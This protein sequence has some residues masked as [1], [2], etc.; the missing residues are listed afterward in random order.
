M[1]KQ[2]QLVLLSIS[3]SILWKT[4][5]LDSFE[6]L[7]RNAKAPQQQPNMKAAEKR[8]FQL[9]LSHHQLQD[10]DPTPSW[11]LWRPF[12]SQINNFYLIGTPFMQSLDICFLNYPVLIGVGDEAID[13]VIAG[14]IIVL[15]HPRWIMFKWIFI[16]TAIFQTRVVI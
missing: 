2:W 3:A 10:E 5:L 1:C 9:N 7:T 15:M 4:W 8:L 16:I 11:I 6:G 12:S 14:V 13:G